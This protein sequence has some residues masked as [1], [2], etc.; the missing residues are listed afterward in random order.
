MVN[1]NWTPHAYVVG[2]LA[3]S[4]FKPSSPI[5]MERQTNPERPEIIDTVHTAP[6][7]TFNETE[8]KMGIGGFKRK[9]SYNQ[10]SITPL[11]PKGISI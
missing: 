5:R 4:A 2:K 11:D 1:N 6:C 10:N 9:S 3:S 8:W 7:C